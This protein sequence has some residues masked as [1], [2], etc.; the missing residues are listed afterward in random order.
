[1]IVLLKAV[2]IKFL[3][4]VVPNHPFDIIEV[5]EL[6]FINLALVHLVQVGTVGL[7]R[8]K[9]PTCCGCSRLKHR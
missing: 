6:L 8:N 3:V 5:K 1:M 2:K 9:E 4:M 7:S